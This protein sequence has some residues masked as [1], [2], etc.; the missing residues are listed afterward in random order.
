MSESIEYEYLFYFFNDA[1]SLVEVKL[2]SLPEGAAIDRVYHWLYIEEENVQ[3]LH[4][5][6]RREQGGLNY[7]EFAQGNLSFDEKMAQ[8]LLHDPAV[9]IELSAAASCN[10]PIESDARVRDFLRRID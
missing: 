5:K 4:F 7:R 2:M 8:L 9:E 3:K 10:I 1:I 6:S